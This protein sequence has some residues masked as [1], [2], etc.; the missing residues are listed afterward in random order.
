MLEFNYDAREPLVMPPAAQGQEGEAVQS[1]AT[2]TRREFTQVFEGGDK[3]PPC[4][5]PGG[6]FGFVNV[7]C[8]DGP[9]ADCTQANS[10]SPFC[11][12]NNTVSTDQPCICSVLYDLENNPCKLT[13]NVLWHGCPEMDVVPNPP[14]FV[15]SPTPVANPNNLPPTTPPGPGGGAVF[16]II[17]LVLFLVALVAFIGGYLYNFGVLGRR[18]VDAIPLIDRCRRGGQRD[19]AVNQADYTNVPSQPGYG[20][21]I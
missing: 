11:L 1:P 10:T 5:N 18:G 21:T 7:W 8:A 16:G 4:L 15:P 2:F 20:S 19:A 13:L 9:L 12:N 14:T 17:V 3:G 6:R